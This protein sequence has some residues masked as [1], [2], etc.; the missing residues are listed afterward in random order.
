MA[1]ATGAEVEQAKIHSNLAWVC[2]ELGDLERAE[3]H[4]DLAAVHAGRVDDPM[5][6]VHVDVIRSD[7]LLRANRLG[8]AARVAEAGLRLARSEGVG[9]SYLVHVLLY[10]AVDAAL[11]MG[12]TAAAAELVVDATDHPVRDDLDLLRELRAEVELRRGRVADGL[13]RLTAP[14]VQPPLLGEEQASRAARLIELRR[15]AGEVDEALDTAQESVDR[16]GVGSGSS[17]W[18]LLT[19]A[20]G[21]AADAAEHSRARRSDAQPEVSSFLRRLELLA[22]GSGAR[23]DREVAAPA[24]LAQWAAERVRAEG[25]DDPEALVGRGADVDL[26][27]APSPGR[28]LLVATR[29]GAACHGSGGAG[30]RSGRRCLAERAGSRRWPRPA[31]GGGRRPGVSRPP[32]PPRRGGPGP[33]RRGARTGAPGA[34]D[35][36]GGA[37]APPRGRRDD[38]RPDRL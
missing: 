13:L 24:F 34:A 6:A 9:T 1:E 2:W 20:A 15:W 26:T 33:F 14:S 5:S 36:P 25:A 29:G 35:R 18:D 30:D 7:F 32:P 17:C 22:A 16:L 12:R 21:A 11:L 38:Q 8:E 4:L 19:A 28:L 10:N 27:G 37:G 3:R 31:A 23:V